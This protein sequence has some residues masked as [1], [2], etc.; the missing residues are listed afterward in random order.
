M[1]W[2][3][4]DVPTWYRNKHGRVTQ[5]WPLDLHTYWSRTLQP[6]LADYELA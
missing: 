2:G 5:N 4:A 6:D 1:V 3:V